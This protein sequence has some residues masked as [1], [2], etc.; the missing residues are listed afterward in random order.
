[1]RRAIGHQLSLALNKTVSQR[2]SGITGLPGSGKLTRNGRP[3]FVARRWQQDDAQTSQQA[4]VTE[5]GAPTPTRELI[6]DW[7]QW[8]GSR[9]ALLARSAR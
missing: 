1:V 4:A 9:Y 3:W 7:A 5:S 2:I 6:R 8:L